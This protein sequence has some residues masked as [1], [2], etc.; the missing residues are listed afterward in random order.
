MLVANQMLR[1]FSWSTYSF[2]GEACEICARH[3]F[4]MRLPCALGLVARTVAAPE[5]PVEAVQ[6]LAGQ[7][8]NVSDALRGR[9]E[10]VLLYH[11]RSKHFLDVQAS[12][13][14]NVDWSSQ[15]SPWK[16][17]GAPSLRLPTDLEATDALSL[18][19]LGAFLR[20][21]AGISA[22][23]S[24]DG[25]H[26]WA[27]RVFPS[28]GNLQT[29]ELHLLL[30]PL[31]DLYHQPAAYHFQPETHSLELRLQ[32]PAELVARSGAK[33][34]VVILTSLCARESWKY[35]ERALRSCHLNLGH[36]VGAL[37][38][39]AEIMGWGLEEGPPALGFY[40]ALAGFHFAEEPELALFVRTEA[41]TAAPEF[42]WPGMGLGAPSP[43]LELD[44][45][46]PFMDAAQRAARVLQADLDAPRPMPRGLTSRLAPLF[47]STSLRGAVLARRS[48]LRMARLA[49]GPAPMPRGDFLKTLQA[50]CSAP[51][52]RAVSLVAPKVHVLLMLHAVQGFEPGLY[53]LLRAGHEPMAMPDLDPTAR[54]EEVPDLSPCEL[55]ALAAPAD[56][57]HAAQVSAC[58][59]ELAGSGSFAAAF[60]GDF[61]NWTHPRSYAELLWQAGALGQV[62]YLAAEAAGFGATGMGCFMDDLALALWRSP[63][64]MEAK[65]TSDLQTFGAEE[66]RYQVLYLAA[67]GKAEV[68]PRLL[69]FEAYQHLQEGFSY[70]ALQGGMG[71]IFPSDGEKMRWLGHH[72]S[73]FAGLFG[74]PVPENPKPELDCHC[75]RFQ[76]ETL[77]D[78]NHL[79]HNVN[80]ARNMFEPAEITQE[81][82]DGAKEV[83]A[84]DMKE[85]EAQS[86][87]TDSFWYAKLPEDI[88]KLAKSGVK[89]KVKRGEEEMEACLAQY[90]DKIER[91][92]S[93]KRKTKAVWELCPP[94]G[95]DKKVPDEDPL[96]CGGT[97][98]L[99]DEKFKWKPG[100][101]MEFIGSCRS[102]LALRHPKMKDFEEDEG[103]RMKLAIKDMTKEYRKKMAEEEAAKKEEEEKAAKE[104]EPKEAEDKLEP[105]D[106]GDRPSKSEQM[107]RARATS[108]P[109]PKGL[110]RPVKVCVR[111]RPVLEREVEHG[112]YHGCVA[113]AHERVYLSTEDK[114]VLIGSKDDPVPDGIKVYPGFD[115]LIDQDSSQEEAF[116]VVG[117][118]AVDGVLL[119]LNAAIMAYGQ[120][121]TG[122]THT[123]VGDKTRPGLCL[124]A[125]GHLF[126]E[127]GLQGSQIEVQAS[128]LQ[129]YLNHITDLLVPNGHEKKLKLRE[130]VEEDGVDTKV[131]GLSERPVESMDDVAALIDEGNQR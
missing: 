91:R 75:F 97:E 24:Y 15:P 8:S 56:V 86:I 18:S 22:W 34:F 35:G 120:T 41:A 55:W 83:I 47:G 76:K 62:L 118:E 95:P 92:N 80:F 107:S 88:A 104:E 126:S 33:G 58:G 9:L 10:A 82:L 32:V 72:A 114:P 43:A 69:S 23:K 49:E 71:R 94:P 109:P 87:T 19:S 11:F 111:V 102:S 84:K 2:G 29:T 108:A 90:P 21:G 74:L 93:L 61:R 70:E 115:G 117:Q 1:R 57:R 85:E 4:L 99:R 122:K 44:G 63:S 101:V 27:L 39:A 7:L 89:V 81:M 113:L 121:S 105:S 116:A 103:E 40:E 16:S 110:K 17:Y 65:A 51:E 26:A 13:P 3:D 98:K 68:D 31:P 79:Q 54:R 128:F 28:S 42:E 37:A 77:E 60:V 127:A 59:Q 50:L 38:A 20:L 5:V 30:P 12:L 45:P 123:M 130:V 131:E 124:K 119:G 67:V 36:A 125:A 112:C 66:A 64:A 78:I 106:S 100:D 52:L 25:L 6:K 46:W 14:E 73:S 96:P 53:L 48:V 129:L